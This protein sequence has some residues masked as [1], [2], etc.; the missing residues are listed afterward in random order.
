MT[1]LNRQVSG[2][3]TGE[4]VASPISHEVFIDDASLGDLSD[5][6]L[7]VGE[8]NM[9]KSLSSI[10]TNRLQQPLLGPDQ[11]YECQSGTWRYSTMRGAAGRP[12][13]RSAGQTANGTA[14]PIRC[15]VLADHLARLNASSTGDRRLPFWKPP[16]P[17]LANGE[18]APPLNSFCF[19]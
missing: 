11:T 12:S 17:A 16:T 3:G 5:V 4:C 9:P 1:R 2:P 19:C 14:P 8:V 13:C 7:R 18:D 15:S 6:A 10:A